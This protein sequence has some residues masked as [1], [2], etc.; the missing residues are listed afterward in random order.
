MP[1]TRKATAR[2]SIANAS[3]RPQRRTAKA[4][5][6][7]ANF[8]EADTLFIEVRTLVRKIGHPCRESREYNS[9]VRANNRT[10]LAQVLAPGAMPIMATNQSGLEPRSNTRRP[11]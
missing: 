7:L 1:A 9:P 4:K 2:H 10:V 11:Q 6:P 8:I 5:K 3:R